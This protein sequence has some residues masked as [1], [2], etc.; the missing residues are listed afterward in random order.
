MRQ[1]REETG[2]G[3]VWRGGGIKRRMDQISF[4]AGQDQRPE[5]HRQ[6][7]TKN[8]KARIYSVDKW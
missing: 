5:G 8:N 7:W 6:K 4:K 3:L 1:L 2:D